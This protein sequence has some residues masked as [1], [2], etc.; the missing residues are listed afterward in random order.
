MKKG[1]NMQE[2]GQKKKRMRKVKKKSVLKEKE[3]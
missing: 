2:K 1:S 3:I